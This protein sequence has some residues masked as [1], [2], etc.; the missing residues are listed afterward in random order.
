MAPTMTSHLILIKFG[1][2]F[3]LIIL[4][5]ANIFLFRFHLSRLWVAYVSIDVDADIGSLGSGEQQFVCEGA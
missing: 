5:I 1:F 2:K 4:L 3:D